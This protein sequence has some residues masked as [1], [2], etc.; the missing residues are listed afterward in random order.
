VILKKSVEVPKSRWSETL[1]TGTL[2][3]TLRHFLTEASLQRCL[4]WW[5]KCFKW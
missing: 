1:T 3:N 2:H 5:S 4:Q